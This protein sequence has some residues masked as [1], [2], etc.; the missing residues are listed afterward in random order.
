MR[1][2]LPPQQQFLNK[3]PFGFEWGACQGSFMTLTGCTVC[4]KLIW[5]DE[6]P[7]MTLRAMQK[8]NVA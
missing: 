5:F 4:L 2:V 1:Y 6:G 8:E 3:G 7:A